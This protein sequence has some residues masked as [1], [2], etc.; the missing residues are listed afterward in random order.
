MAEEVKKEKE[1]PVEKDNGYLEVADF[2]EVVHYDPALY[3]NGVKKYKIK[4]D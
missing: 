1:A 2:I 3:P 4:Q